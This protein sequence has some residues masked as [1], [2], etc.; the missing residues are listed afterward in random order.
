MKLAV[1]KTD[2]DVKTLGDAYQEIIKAGNIKEFV[3]MAE[4]PSNILT[5][6]WEVINQALRLEKG[7]A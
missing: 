6:E 4:H 2:E 7:H 3:S 5:P 1:L